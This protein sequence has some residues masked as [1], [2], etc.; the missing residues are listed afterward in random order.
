MSRIGIP[1]LLALALSSC[2]GE[3]PAV[4]P[5]PKPTP[6]AADKPPVLPLI[7]RTVLFGNPDKTEP[8]LSP[9]GKWLSYLAP[10]K[11]VLNLWVAPLADPSKA[12]ALT[13]DT[14]R[15]VR[16]AEW[17]YDSQHVLYVQDDG[18]DENWRLFSVGVEGGKSLDLTPVKGVQ[19]RLVHRSPKK[20]TTVLVGLNERDKKWHDVFAVDVTT[21]NR[22]LLEKNEGFASYLANDDLELVLA[23]KNTDDGGSEIFRKVP[24]KGWVSILAVPPDDALTTE[25]QVLSRDGKNLFLLDSRGRDRAVLARLELDTGKEEVLAEDQKAD[26]VEVLTN[27]ATHE[28][29]AAAAVY[30]QKSWLVLDP[31]LTDD[32]TRLA[33]AFPGELDVV[34]QSDDNRHWLVSYSLDTGPKRTAHYDRTTHAVTPLF[35]DRPEFAKYELAPMVPVT[36]RARDGLELVSYV[37]FPRGAGAGPDAKPAQPYPMVLFVHGGPWSRDHWGLNPW[38][39]WL[40]NRGYVVLSVNYRGSTGFGKAFVN[41]GDKQWAAK[42]HDDLLDAVSWAVERRITRPGQV[43]IMGGSYG[44]YATLVGLSFTPSTFACGVD[45]VGPSNLVTLLESIPPYWASYRAT[46][47]R[48]IGDPRTEEGRRLLRERSPLSRADA[49]VRPLLIGQGRNDPRVKPAESEQIV[50]AM[51]GRGV[52][53]TYVVYPDEGHGFARP[54][55]R[56]SFNAIA[57]AF[58]KQCLGGRREPFGKAFEGA[59]LEVVEGA[60]DIEGLA[61]AL[62]R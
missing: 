42:M 56:D 1:F 33:K 17:A 51:K 32:F 12:R 35:V 50:G 16:G 4:T 45:I 36:I 11:G 21:G 34:S 9:D 20:P 43:A 18:G 5:T 57:E 37:T 58:L 40:A 30:A 38:H 7:P 60:D 26:V 44:G 14:G 46:F 8:R 52:P 3:P 24:K 54:E 19:A 28:P 48:R 62:Q 23:V 22:T 29:E 15:G 55:N 6:Q 49:I 27:P 59:S 25:P 39:Q 41:A 13:H 61:P 47:S 53:V 10:E 2:H 31:K